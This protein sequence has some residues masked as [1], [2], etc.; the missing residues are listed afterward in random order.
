MKHLF[1]TT[2]IALSLAACGSSGSSAPSTQS[3]TKQHTP[4]YRIAR[5]RVFRR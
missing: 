3:N 2:I 1:S 4:I 5:C